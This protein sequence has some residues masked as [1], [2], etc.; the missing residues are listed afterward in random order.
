M[1]PINSPANH[2]SSGRPEGLGGFGPLKKSGPISKPEGDG[3]APGL[4]GKPSLDKQ[5][6][7]A[8]PAKSWKGVIPDKNA[9]D[10][11]FRPNQQ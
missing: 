7:L 9:G 8:S 10:A 2:G 11:P 3:R 6:P 1:G 5:G 4:P